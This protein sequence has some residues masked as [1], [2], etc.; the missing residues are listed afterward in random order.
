MT[1]K[2]FGC[3]IVSAAFAFAQSSITGLNPSRARAGSPATPLAISGK[4]LGSTASV[5]WTTPD[6][7]KVSFSPSQVAAA[8]VSASIPAALLSTAGTAQVALADGA[9]VL[10]NQLPFTIGTPLMSVPSTQLP[11]GAVGATYSSVVLAAANGTAPYSWK[12]LHG[13]LPA[14]MSLDPNGTVSGI[15]SV[16]GGFAFAAQATDANHAKAVGTI[17]I[18]IAAAPLQITV[19]A[20]FPA[21]IATTE[22]PSQI[23]TAT[24]GIAPYTFRIT[25][26]LPAGLSFSNGQITGTPTTAGSSTFTIGVT[27]SA[28]TPQTASI[29]AQL[30]I[31]PAQTDLILDLNNASFA[32]TTGSSAVPPPDVFTVSSS[33][34]TKAINYSTIVTPAVPWLTVTSGA[35]LA[36]SPTPNTINVS[37]SNA[38]L[39]LAAAATP[40]QTSIVVTCLAPAT[41][42]GNTQSIA[43]S[44]TVTA[45]PPQLS[46]LSS[47]LTFIGS[48]ANPQRS[49]QAVDLQNTGGG[50]ISIT[51]VTA[52]DLWLTI[53]SLPATLAGGP[54]VSIPVTADPTGLKPGYYKTSIDVVTS[55][56]R[57]SIPASIQVLPTAAMTLSPAGTEV[58]SV[59]GNAPG[60]TSGSFGVGVASSAVTAFTATVLPGAPWL[61]VT[62]GTGTAISAFSGAVSYAIDPVA[63]AA[64]A[65][66]AYYGIIRVTAPGVANSPQDFLVVLNVAAATSPALPDPQPAGLLFIAS[67]GTPAAQTVQLFASAKTAVPYEASATTTDGRS[68]L[69]VTPAT[70]TTSAAAP[71]QS[72]IAVSLTGLA[73]GV[74]RGG[75]NYSYSGVSVRTVNVTLIVQPQAATVTTTGA[76][77]SL[78]PRAT[79]LCTPTQVVP[80]QTGLVN[81]FAAP[82]SWPTPMTILLV[83]NCGNPVTNGQIEA[84]FSTS[85]PPLFFT[86]K[87]RSSGIYSAT[88]TPRATS[89]VISITA[90]ASATGLTGTTLLLAGQVKPNVAPSV[91]AHAVLN[92]F[93]P[94]VG[95]A[96]SPGTVIQI[97][98]NGLA[99]QPI[100]PGVIPLQTT[101]SGTTVII[102]G[103][104][105]P[106]FYVSSGQINAQIPFELSPDQQ[107]DV[108][109]YANGAPTIPEPIQL[110]AAAPGVLTFFS[111]ETIAQHQAGGF[112]SDDSPAIPG[113]FLVFYV[114][115]MGPIDTTVSTGGGAPGLN[116]GDPLA[117]PTNVPT[118]TL[119]GKDLPI[120]FSGL[121]PGLVG[122]YQINFQ[123]PLDAKN[124]NL[125]LVLSQ[126]GGGS[127]TS[128]LPVYQ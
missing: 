35:S 44:L 11:S 81:N 58:N 97:Y 79:T 59:T 77:G 76:T 64:L 17:T 61:T 31:K 68:W 111:G 34:A 127:S 46:V 45:A 48:S 18:S 71:A 38:A 57:A 2:L 91:N 30:T 9:G 78:G 92:I 74:Y 8:Q 47:V 7:R 49:T 114:A 6:G 69:S 54:P 73:A 37:L 101:V 39:S 53:G 51:S 62:R 119:D 55:A 89:S 107:Y 115:G 5:S 84:D 22:Y 90:K 118:L 102:G 123:V 82:A 25:G 95:G 67:T 122:L 66:Q 10:T 87:D 4:T 109:V 23:L 40:Y 99:N 83:D 27:D 13:G 121:T 116:P 3:L 72:S 113:E 126:N 104:S 1:P 128:T 63:A 41:C 29:S 70:G 103:I 105:A 50:S 117:H 120:A 106:L 94:E 75:V 56:G 42:A 125:D 86:A 100:A 112:V 12:L 28:S 43:V 20:T 16:P 85:D 14:G 24:G 108:I 93:D 80:A 32:I 98:G 33:V 19:G 96:L 88:W 26:A 110:T 15:P 21:G 124:G 65:P 36:S 52:A 60:N